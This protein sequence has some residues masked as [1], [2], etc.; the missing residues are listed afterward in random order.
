MIAPD[1]AAVAGTPE[2]GGALVGVATWAYGS[3]RAVLGTYLNTSDVA[4]ARVE[5]TDIASNAAH[6]PGNAGAQ[7]QRQQQH[8]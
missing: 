7:V 2:A 3:P 1:P 5:A 8:G 4:R 6:V